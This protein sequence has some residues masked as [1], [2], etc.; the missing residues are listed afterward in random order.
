MPSGL[1]RTTSTI[2]TLARTGRIVSARKLFDEM[3]QRD[4]IAWN[5]MLAGYSQSGRA[6]EALSLFCHMRVAD[7]VPDNFSFTAILSASADAGELLYGKRIH[8]LVIGLGYQSYLPVCNSLVDMYGKCHSPCCAVQVFDEMNLRNEVSWCSTLFAYVKAG[9]LGDAH[10]LFDR[11]PSKGEFAWNM[12]IAGYARCGEIELCLSLFKDMQQAACQPDLCTFTGLMNACAEVAELRYG[13]MVHSCIIKSGWSSAVEANNSILSFYAKLSCLHDAVKAFASART[14]TQVSWNAMIDAFMKVGDIDYALALF[15]QSPEKNIISWTAIISGYAR[16]GHGEEALVFFVDMMRNLIKPDDFTFGA[17]LHAC[18]NL[19]VLGCGRMVHGSALRHGFHP[20]TYVGNGLVNMY[21][22]CGD[23]EGSCQAFTDIINKDLV[24]WNAMLFGFGL[25]GKAFEAIKLFEEMVGTGVRPDEVTFIGL[26]MACSHS[27]LIEQG[28]VF[29]ELMASAY[30]VSHE[31]DH[32]TCMVDML[33]RGGYLKEAREL[34]E[35]YSSTVSMKTS[36]HEALLGA[37]VAYENVGLG[38]K[39]GEDLMI[40]EPQRELSYVLLSNLYCA[41]GKW[42]E[43]EKVRKAMVEQ[44]VKKMPGCSWIE[45]G[46]RVMVF[47]AGKH[48]YPHMEDLYT[49][50][51]FLKSEMRNPNLFGFENYKARMKPPDVFVCVI[52]LKQN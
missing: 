35:E 51:N 34:V 21:T 13:S 45:V 23:F 43:A 14:R 19:A 12:L 28:L 5:A 42:K 38:A 3:P 15:W 31:A 6:Q 8:A 27:G 20:F 52:T 10:E 9:Q 47:V 1:F 39:V 50:L 36:S 40:I 7:M 37:C 22:K 18:S 25:H 29:F 16:N 11:M 2:V 26:L 4:S 33:G 48:S 41:S 46:N 17:I 24:S 49:I 30:G 32:L 44:G